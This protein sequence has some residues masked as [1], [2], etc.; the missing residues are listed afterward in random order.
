MHNDAII[1]Y[2]KLRRNLMD[3]RMKVEKVIGTEIP[4]K[5][6]GN[7]QHFGKIKIQGTNIMKQVNK[8]IIQYKTNDCKKNKQSKGRRNAAMHSF[9][10]PYIIKEKVIYYGNSKAYCICNV[11]IQ[12]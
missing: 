7:C 1:R 12:F 6:P 4:Y 3:S 11:F 2:H 9:E 8:N 10:R 5:Y